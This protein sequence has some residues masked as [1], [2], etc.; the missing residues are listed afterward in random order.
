MA[1]PGKAETA[2][3]KRRRFHA[4]ELLA[5]DGGAEHRVLLDGADDRLALNQEE[6]IDRPTQHAGQ[7]AE[8]QHSDIGKGDPGVRNEQGVAAQPGQVQVE[9][10]GGLLLAVAL[11]LDRDGLRRLA[12]ASRGLA[13]R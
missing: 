12:G 9:R 3:N 4:R 6:R 1:K 7:Y 10:L 5:G 2:G 13:W 11:D 8:H